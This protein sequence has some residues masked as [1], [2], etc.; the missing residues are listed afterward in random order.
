MR[1]YNTHGSDLVVGALVA[2]A[3]A[4]GL[5]WIYSQPRLRRV[6]G[7]APE[8]L[9]PKPDHYVGV[10]SYFAHGMRHGGDNSMYGEGIVV[11]LRSLPKGPFQWRRYAD[12]FSE[13]FGPG[14]EYVGYIDTP[15]RQTLTNQIVSEMDLRTRAGRLPFDGDEAD[16]VSVLHKVMGAY[17]VSR[18]DDLR[19]RVNEAIT[20]TKGGEAQLDL[21]G[22]MID[23][24]ESEERFPGADDEQ[25]P[26]LTKVPPLV[27]RYR[28]DPNWERYVEEAVRVSANNDTAVEWARFFTRLLVW[29]SGEQARHGDLAEEI[30]RIVAEFSGGVQTVVK[31]ALSRQGE[32][33][34][35]V[36]LKLGLACEL[37]MGVPLALHILL[38]SH[39]YPTAVRKNILCG[40][41]SCGRAVVVGSLA[42]ALWGETIPQ[43]W[44]RRT[45]RTVEVMRLLQGDE[46]P[47]SR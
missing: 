34:K 37:V 3:A 43:D 10:P 35:A 33:S 16:K 42:A 11:V 46:E 29:A 15:T 19:Q 25:L 26:A 40:G 7:E 30:A 23:L 20:Q 12:A 45:A 38:N 32:D 28:D 41:D 21:A 31:R 4:L 47:S 39:D 14:G 9:E 18:G 22:R 27:A 1:T 24:L 8:F 17:S 13:H 5:H 36:G 44:V 6:G 2:D